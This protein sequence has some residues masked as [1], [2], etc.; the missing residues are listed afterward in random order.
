LINIKESKENSKDK[1][2]KLNKKQEKLVINLKN[3]K[4]NFTLC[5]LYQHHLIM[6]RRNLWMNWL[7][8]VMN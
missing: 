4:K 8:R 5:K 1:F 6:R 3:L 7:K 2:N